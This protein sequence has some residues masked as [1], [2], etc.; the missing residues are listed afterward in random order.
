MHLCPTLEWSKSWHEGT[1]CHKLGV[2]VPKCEAML[3]DQHTIENEMDGEDLQRT[4]AR[5]PR[6]SVEQACLASV[7]L[8]R[9][10]LD[11]KIKPNK[12]E[13]CPALSRGALMAQPSPDHRRR[14][15]WW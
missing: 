13:W 12:D 11:C 9:F 14:Q 7:D 2:I 3:R 15:R 6:C 5:P 8:I 4:W 1:H 10:A